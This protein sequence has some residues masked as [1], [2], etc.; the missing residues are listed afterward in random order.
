MAPAPTPSLNHFHSHLSQ[1]VDG[2]G[3]QIPFTWT[4]WTSRK[5]I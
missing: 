2:K 4:L 3:S 5:Y 1:I